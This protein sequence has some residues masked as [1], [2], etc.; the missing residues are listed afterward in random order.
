MVFKMA[1]IVVTLL[2]KNLAQNYLTDFIQIFTK[3]V[4]QP[5]IDQTN[6]VLNQ[7]RQSNPVFNINILFP[8]M[9]ISGYLK[10][11]IVGSI[12][13]GAGFRGGVQ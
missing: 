3:H 8:K 2:Y 12:W 10:I 7:I 6:V 1:C 4:F 13:E 5:D 11:W 9:C